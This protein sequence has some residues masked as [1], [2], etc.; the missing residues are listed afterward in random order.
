M[1]RGRTCEKCE[2][3][4]FLTVHHRHYKTLGNESRKDVKI[5][6]WKCHHRLHQI[7][8]FTKKRRL[9]NV[10]EKDKTWAEIV[11]TLWKKK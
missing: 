10:Q 5:L 4:R 2:S 3:K 9:I 11:K 8:Y 6:C 1:E 7:V